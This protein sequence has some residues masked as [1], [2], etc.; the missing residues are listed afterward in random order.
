MGFWHDRKPVK[1]HKKS[2]TLRA[3]SMPFFIGTTCVYGFS[4]RSKGLRIFN[5]MR[6]PFFCFINYLIFF[7]LHD[8]R[9]SIYLIR[10]DWY[11]SPI[12]I[13][14]W[15]TVYFFNKQNLSK[16]CTVAIRNSICWRSTNKHNCVSGTPLARILKT[17]S[18]ETGTEGGYEN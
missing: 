8:R 16:R 14:N 17:Y 18:G 6:R 2:V 5:R 10:G 15:S 4:A 11:E 9:R 13:D 1:L 7:F 12:S 3:F